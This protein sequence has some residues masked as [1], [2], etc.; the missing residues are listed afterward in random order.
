MGAVSMRLMPRSRALRQVATATSSGTA[1]QSSPPMAQVPRPIRE[2]FTPAMVVV[3]MH[4]ILS[5]AQGAGC[6][7][8]QGNRGLLTFIP[9]DLILR[10]RRFF[11]LVLFLASFAVAPLAHAQGGPPFITDD[12]GTPGNRQWEINLGFMGNHNPAHASYQLPNIDINYGWGDRIQLM[13]S[14]YLARS[15]ERRVGKECR[16]R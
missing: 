8:K 16:S 10:M 1:P 7:F 11:Q 5:V 2:T 4:N 12:P 6:Y 14:P 3:S 15:E 9:R 13:V